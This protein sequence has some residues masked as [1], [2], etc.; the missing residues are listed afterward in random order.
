MV[1]TTTTTT[2]VLIAYKWGLSSRRWWW[3]VCIWAW[4]I[5]FV[6]RTNP[7]SIYINSPSCSYKPCV[8]G[9]CQVSR[10]AVPCSIQYLPITLHNDVLTLSKMKSF[11]ASS[12]KHFLP[13][14]ADT[15][16]RENRDLGIEPRIGHI[17]NSIEG[18]WCPNLNFIFCHIRAF[19]L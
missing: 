18:L 15:I 2:A 8:G 9:W 3:Y 6:Y 12:K 1:F 14:K 13:S 7:I 10:A 5:S 19:P 4:N 16:S 11:L 17:G